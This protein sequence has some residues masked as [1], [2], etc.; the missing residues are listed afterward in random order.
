MLRRLRRQQRPLLLQLQLL[1]LL[2]WLLPLLLRLSSGAEVRPL[3]LLLEGL[4]RHHDYVVVVVL[5]SM[6]PPSPAVTWL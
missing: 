4:C 1:V 2:L 6:R 3:L 5:V